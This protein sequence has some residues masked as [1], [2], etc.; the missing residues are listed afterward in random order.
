MMAGFIGQDWTVVDWTTGSV[1][2]TIGVGE[3]RLWKEAGRQVAIVCEKTK[4]K[5][6]ELGDKLMA[7]S[8]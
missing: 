8:E 4:V 2:W 3:G 5:V 7:E 6:V 1:A